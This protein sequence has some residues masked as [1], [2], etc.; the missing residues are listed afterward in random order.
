MDFKSDLGPRAGVT[1]Q[2]LFSEYPGQIRL[3]VFNF[4]TETDT[5]SQKAAEAFECADDQGLAFKME[6][7]MLGN[8]DDLSIGMLKVFASE[9]GLNRPRF[10]RCL[11]NGEKINEI[12]MQKQVG[13]DNGVNVTPTFFIKGRKLEGSPSLTVFSQII[14]SD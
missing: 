13:L 8:N 11:D 6:E 1:I 2:S 14:E 9:I 10:D 4:P 7:K 3:V 12:S 5:E